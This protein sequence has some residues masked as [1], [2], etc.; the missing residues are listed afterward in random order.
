LAA[1]TS[2]EDLILK[3][4]PVPEK[5]FFYSRFLSELS[6]YIAFILVVANKLFKRI[7]LSRTPLDLP[8]LFFIGSAVIS[9]IVNH[10]PI[11]GSIVNL[12]PLLRFILLFYLIVNLKITVN[13]ASKITHS[14]IWAGTLQVAIGMLQYLSRGA[15]DNLLLPR[16]TDI[17]IGGVSKTYILLKT[18]REAGSIYAAAGDTVIYSVFLVLIFILIISKQ[19]TLFF[20]KNKKNTV[21][22]KDKFA[23]NKKNITKILPL[24]R[25]LFLFIA[26]ALTYVRSSLFA[27]IIIGLRHSARTFG[28]VKT[29]IV[30]FLAMVLVIIVFTA[31]PP[32]FISEA[33]ST[34]KSIFSDISGIFTPEYINVAKKQR[35]GALIGI[36]PTVIFNKPILGYGADQISAIDGLNASKISF[37]TKVWTEE[38][39]KDVYWAA[40]LTFY[41]LAGLISMAWMFWRL[42]YC[43]RMIYKF[44]NQQI[45]KEIS[46][47]VRYI[48]ISTSFL[49]FL[50][51]A[52]EF[53][54]YGFY[55]WLL[56][57]L[58]FSLYIQEKNNSDNFVKKQSALDEKYK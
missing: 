38:G 1:I 48:V 46:L 52:I 10:S 18:G 54:I 42:Y 56:P 11:F 37:L 14:I 35:L 19:H 13:Q 15:L 53:R 47:A 30:L 21:L 41:G 50:N 3:F 31:I 9:I 40:I 34:Q 43:A 23:R 16:A 8:I 6:I 20:V 45:T 44:S 4:L 12:R 25:I 27:A 28:R 36:V 39:F 5:I 51:R 2:F 32:E 24:I 26:I 33:K 49:L 58:M 17:D 57:G 29:F 7:P 55:F 22:I